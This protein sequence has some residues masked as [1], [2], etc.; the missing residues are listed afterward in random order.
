MKMI[1]N[2]SA[3]YWRVVAILVL[4]SCAGG[5]ASAQTDPSFGPLARGWSALASAQPA[6]AIAQADQVLAASP[7]S[8]EGISLKVAALAPMDPRRALDAYEQWSAASRRDDV[9]VIEPIAKA[10]LGDV[11]S[12][13]GPDPLLRFEALATLA[14][15]GD[16]GARAQIESAATTDPS[17]VGAAV[18]GAALGDARS[19]A[20]LRR[21]AASNE[22]ADKSA[23]VRALADSKDPSAAAI[24]L[25]LLKD[26]SPVT[27]AAA[28]TALGEL[29]ASSATA[30]LRDALRDPVSVVRSSAAVALHLLGDT[31]GDDLLSGMLNGDVPELRLMAAAA[32]RDDPRGTWVEAIRPLL[33]DPDGL[34]RFKAAELLAKLEPDAARAAVHSGFASANPNVR[35]EAARVL[36]GDLPD[37][38]ATLRV[39]LRDGSAWVRLHAARGVL[40]LAGALN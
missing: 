10:V 17:S 37:D 16:S 26:P 9:F 2:T 36:A 23:I 34:N 18:S 24:L 31:G 19:M 39:L 25:P 27:R 6:V 7:R 35:E 38:V 15:I 11:A 5:R 32:F 29:R 12:K 28:A 14:R 13:A 4:T 33:N 3:E 20:S 22:V 21:L 30:G 40:K 8:H 1:M